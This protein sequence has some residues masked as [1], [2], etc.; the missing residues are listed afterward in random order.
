M[1][2]VALPALTAR[3]PPPLFSARIPKVA[4]PVVST[5]PVAVTFRPPAPPPSKAHIPWPAAVTLPALRVASPP[6]DSI[7]MPAAP[8]A[9]PTAVTEPVTATDSVPL[10]AFDMRMPCW[11]PTTRSTR[12]EMFPPFS[13]TRV[14]MAAMPEA[15]TSPVAVR[16]VVPLPLFSACIP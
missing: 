8:G 7:R 10:P 5:A 16:F 14:S 13:E 11:P 2:P 3:F 15:D 1:A 6:A 4:L 9:V 12:M